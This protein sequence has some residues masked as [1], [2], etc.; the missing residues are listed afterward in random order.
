[1]SCDTYKQMAGSTKVPFYGVVWMPIK[2]RNMKMEEIFVISQIRE[3]VILGMPFL[4]N[5]GCKMGFTCSDYWRAG[6]CVY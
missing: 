5:P 6:A 1:M 3:D 4:A 2:V